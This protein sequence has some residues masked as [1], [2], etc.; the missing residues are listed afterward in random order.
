[1]DNVEIVRKAFTIE[2]WEEGQDL[3]AD[4]FQSTDEAGSPPFDKDT[5]FGMGQML[6]ASFPD[7]ENVIDD[8][9]EEGEDVSVTSHF[10]GT[11]ANDLDLSAV[12]L[13]VIPA[14]GKKVTWPPGT[15]LV[16]LEGGKITRIHNTET[17]PDA[18]MAGFLK[19]LGVG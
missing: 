2:H 13:G 9:R 4:S 14:S 12:G 11:F 19:V 7:L 5:W 16:T 8:I 18:G 3:L 10:V 15:S 17:G 6:Q 1:M